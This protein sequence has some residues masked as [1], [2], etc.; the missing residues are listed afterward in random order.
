[1][2]L[3][4]RTITA[5]FSVAVNDGLDANQAFD[6]LYLSGVVVQFTPRPGRLKDGNVTTFLTTIEG[7]TDGTGHL[8][9]LD[10]QIG[11]P[12]PVRD[13][14]EGLT[15]YEV[16]VIPP[17][18]SELQP[19][20]FM[21]TVSPGTTPLDISSTAGMFPSNPGM[22]E[23]WVGETTPPNEASGVWWLDITDPYRYK[24]W[25]WVA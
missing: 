2:A 16:R 5:R 14:S 23:L 21:L 25:K 22:V 24:L 9:S 15:V 20:A 8:K 6:N 13:P 11:V 18:G 17:D 1:M 12:L 3:F 7:V 19:Y 4:S 10:G